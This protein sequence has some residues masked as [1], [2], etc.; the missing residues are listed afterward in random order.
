MFLAGH[1][2]MGVA[3]V[4]Y[5]LEKAAGLLLLGSAMLPATSG[6]F[7]TAHTWC[8]AAR[9]A[10]PPWTTQLC[11]FNKS[12]YRSPLRFTLHA[13]GSPRHAQLPCI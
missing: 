8:A 6:L 2:L 4:R 11:H 12:L 1:S 7:P 3:A 13:A 5:G 10:Q 9:V